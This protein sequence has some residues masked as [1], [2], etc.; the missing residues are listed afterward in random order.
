METKKNIITLEDIKLL[1][2]QFYGKVREDKLLSPIFNERIKDRWPQHL[3]KMYKFWQTVLLGGHTYYGSPFPPHAHL[4]IEKGHFNQ[5]LILFHQT[6]DEH[7]EGQ[8]ADEAKWRAERMAEMFRYKIDY[9][10][11]NPSKAIL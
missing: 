4:P 6:V 11:N 7:F 3:E 2:D 9:L 8:K 10:R 1:V 5:W